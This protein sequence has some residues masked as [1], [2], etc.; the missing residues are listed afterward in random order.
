MMMAR[1]RCSQHCGQIQAVGREHAVQD[2]KDLFGDLRTESEPMRCRRSRRGAANH[3]DLT[4][5]QLCFFN[6]FFCGLFGLSADILS[7][8]GF[9]FHTGRK[10]VRSSSVNSAIPATRPTAACGRFFVTADSRLGA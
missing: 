8:D 3:D 2:G 6:Q 7:M 4:G 1:F 10:C 9:S 5:M